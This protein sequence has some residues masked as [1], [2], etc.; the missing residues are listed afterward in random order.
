MQEVKQQ[1]EDK[2]VQ[3]AELKALCEQQKVNIICLLMYYEASEEITCL[4]AVLWIIGPAHIICETGS[5]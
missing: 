5:L 1:L 3:I 4:S 2:E